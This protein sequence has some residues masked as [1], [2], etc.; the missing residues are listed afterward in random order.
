MLGRFGGNLGGL[1]R[2]GG[3]N[4]ELVFVLG[5]VWTCQKGLATAYCLV[6]PYKTDPE[7]LRSVGRL[8]ARFGFSRCG[9]PSGLERQHAPLLSASTFGTQESI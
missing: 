5:A 2:G 3:S 7:R 4:L 8:W 6:G 9:A 1:L